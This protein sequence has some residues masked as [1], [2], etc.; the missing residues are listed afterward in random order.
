MEKEEKGFIAGGVPFKKEVFCV[1]ACAGERCVGRE[2]PPADMSYSFYR[3]TIGGEKGDY[4]RYQLYSVAD[5]KC[6]NE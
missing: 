5:K 6:R 3:R 4:I 2:I 1:C